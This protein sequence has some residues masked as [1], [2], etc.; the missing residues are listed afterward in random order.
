DSLDQR[1]ATLP[2]SCASPEYVISTVDAEAK[3]AIVAYI[4][5]AMSAQQGEKITIDGF[6]IEFEA[7][8]GLV[9]AS[10]TSNAVSLRFEANNDELLEK[11]KKLFKAGLSRA[12][13]RLSIPF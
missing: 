7:G 5:E 11:L 4:A 6:R 2:S 1:L 8:W 9:R 12:D 3:H 13:D 10:N